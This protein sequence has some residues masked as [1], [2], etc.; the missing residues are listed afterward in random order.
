MVSSIFSTTGRPAGVANG[1][2][3]DPILWNASYETTAGLD[4]I[5]AN[6][7]A[8]GEAFLLMAEAPASFDGRYFGVTKV[9]DI[10]GKAHLL[11]AR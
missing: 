6:I 7:P 1:S 10:V 3:S 8:K 2:S 11:W 5:L 4:A 9:S